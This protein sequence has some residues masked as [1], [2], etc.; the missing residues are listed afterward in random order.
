[1]NHIIEVKLKFRKR[2]HPNFF[3]RVFSF[4]Y[5]KIKTG[6]IFNY[7]AFLGAYGINDLDISSMEN[8]DE[9][10]KISHVC[11]GAALEYCRENKKRIFFES[12]DI[13]DALLMASLQTNED[14]GKA[15]TYARM[16]DWL[17]TVMD[18][19]PEKKDDGIKKK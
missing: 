12:T 16:P 3:V 9:V 14:I 17:Q 11:Y 4:R 18:G 8:M 10:E 13:K 2:L 15:L 7:R 19:L 1:M 5:A 6:F